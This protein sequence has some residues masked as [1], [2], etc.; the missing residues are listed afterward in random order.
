MPEYFVRTNSDRVIEI[1]ADGCFMDREA[2]IYT[3]N[4]DGKPVASFNYHSVL[5]VI[6]E[7]VFKGEWSAIDDE[8]DARATQNLDDVC[9]DCRNQELLNSE[10]FFDSVYDIVD[11]YHQPD[12]EAHSDVPALPPSDPFPIEHWKN[13]VGDEYWGFQTAKGFVDFYE[14]GEAEE[15]RKTHLE[16]PDVDWAYK[17]LTGFTKGED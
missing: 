9:I 10:A 6:Q 8:L 4:K 11:A 14:K 13:E 12:E 17:D 2:G 7:P 5:G 3:F 15:G 1:E 16:H